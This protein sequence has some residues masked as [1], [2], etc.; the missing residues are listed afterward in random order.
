MNLD[1]LKILVFEK[2]EATKSNR[3]KL[4]KLAKANK[5]INTIEK[6]RDDFGFKSAKIYLAK[7]DNQSLDDAIKNRDFES[8]K[9]FIEVLKDKTKVNTE[10]LIEKK[11]D[12]I[13]LELL[14]TKGFYVN[15]AHLVKKKYKLETIKLAIENGAKVDEL[16]ENMNALFYAIQANDLDRVRVLLELKAKVNTRFNHGLTALYLAMDNIEIVKLLLKYGADMNNQVSN[17][18]TLL[19]Q[20]SSENNIELVKVLLDNGADINIKTANKGTALIVAIARQNVEVI[21]ILLEHGADVN[22][23]EITGATPLDMAKAHNNE[24]IIN[25]LLQKGAKST[26]S[27]IPPFHQAFVDKNI[28]DIERLLNLGHNIDEENES[29]TALMYASSIGDIEMVNLLLSYGADINR[30]TKRGVFALSM[31]SF[32][33]HYNVVKYL[34][35]NGA[36]KNMQGYGGLSAL[37]LAKQKN[38]Q[39][40]IQLLETNNQNTNITNPFDMD[41]QSI[42]EKNIENDFKEIAHNLIREK[43]FEEAQKYISNM[44]EEDNERELYNLKR[45]SM[46]FQKRSVRRVTLTNEEMST[47]LFIKSVRGYNGSLIHPDLSGVEFQS[48][49]TNIGYF[50][51]TPTNISII[52]PLTHTAFPLGHNWEEEMGIGK[53]FEFGNTSP[54]FFLSDLGHIFLKY[55]DENHIKS[56][57]LYT[58]EADNYIL[59]K[60]LQDFDYVSNN[61]YQELYNLCE[62]SSS[63]IIISKLKKLLQK[64]IDI[65]KINDDTKTALMIASERGNIETIEFLLDNG[66]DI[67]IQDIEGFTALMLASGRG[68]YEISLKLIDNGASIKTENYR[69]Q[70]A[71]FFALK[72]M[73]PDIIELMEEKGANINKIQ[74]L[75][76][77]N[78]EKEKAMLIFSDIEKKL[79]SKELIT[80]FL[81]YA[82]HYNFDYELNLDYYIENNPDYLVVFQMGKDEKFDKKVVRA[83]ND[84]HDIYLK[85]LNVSDEIKNKIRT[86]VFDL[87]ME[88]YE[89]GKYENSRFAE[90]LEVKNS[91][92]LLD[93][94]TINE[95]DYI[96]KINV[97]NSYLKLDI[98]NTKDKKIYSFTYQEEKVNLY[99][100]EDRGELIIS[101]NK[102]IEKDKNGNQRISNFTREDSSLLIK[103]REVH[104]PKALLDILNKFSS[105]EK[106]K[107]TNHTFDKD[108]DYDIFIQKLKIGFEEI[109]TNLEILSPTLYKSINDLL[110]SEDEDI[111]GWSSTVIKD[112]I[113]QG[114]LNSDL[115]NKLQEKVKSLIVVKPND[116]EISLLQRFIEIRKEFKKVNNFEI[117]IDLN[118]LKE[119][120]IDKFFT[121]TQRFEQ[122][123]KIIFKDINENSKDS[124]KKVIVEANEDTINGMP[125][126]EI[127]IIHIDSESLTNSE[128]LKKAITKNGGNFKSIYNNL[129][130]VCDWS[131]D[132]VCSDGRYRIDY[133]YPQIDNNK[134]HC[135]PLE[136]TIRGFTHILRFY[137]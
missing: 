88:K 67:N 113:E 85:S 39:N 51:D 63:T 1:K 92:Y 40:I 48:I 28:E 121:D 22:V 79:I 94:L 64:N 19:I 108:I 103:D 118:G 3:D 80:E 44:T 107:Y 83:Y 65:N 8:F 11:Y 101:K 25:L 95:D 84:I 66:A 97:Y 130:S 117:K 60:E 68:H 87:L 27:S 98:T 53:D 16:Y 56:K 125:M 42:I 5:D 70:D 106:I 100:N 126:V 111:Q 116:K 30:Q 17:G 81:L 74:S 7:L 132:T 12:D 20:A 131:I 59:K 15:V 46:P 58:M 71:T 43:G 93:I 109:C 37:D 99:K 89:L 134:P 14:I 96:A 119:I 29:G 133:L 24:T 122:A 110:F 129:L 114:N 36:D 50:I 91:D 69:G 86:K 52:N 75:N 33:G 54:L 35:E 78:L 90:P 41:M 57:S 104:T 128:N 62:E 47:P 18:L 61:L 23:V 13:F 55:S 32:Y 26:N 102:I 9:K 127:R 112:E 21:K 105:D 10:E 77:T 135:I 49:K 73:Y 72:N 82:L 76:A 115:I 34:L 120:S 45:D 6:L 2:N 123:I 4:F 38:H 124:T 31:A 136:D 137:K